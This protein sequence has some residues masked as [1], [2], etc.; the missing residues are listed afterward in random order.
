[1]THK[2]G[3]GD[4]DEDVGDGAADE[5]EVDEHHMRLVVQS[6]DVLSATGRSAI[7]GENTTPHAAGDLGYCDLDWKWV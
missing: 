3:H 5:P 7:E 4:R 1:M 6:S 2:G